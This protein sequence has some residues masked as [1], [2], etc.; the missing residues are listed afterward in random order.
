MPNQDSSGDPGQ[1]VEKYLQAGQLVGEATVKMYGVASMMAEE[2]IPLEEIGPQQN[3]ASE[4]LI[5]ALALLQPPQQEPQ[6]E[7]KKSPEQ[8]QANEPQQ[9]DA[10]QRS[11][12]DMNQMLQGVRD[13]EAQRRQDQQ[14]RQKQGAGYQPVEKDW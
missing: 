4:D 8:E 2:K 9:Q 12:G 11:D 7:Q 5:R 3:A 14:D 10:D 1:M 13:R 6:Q